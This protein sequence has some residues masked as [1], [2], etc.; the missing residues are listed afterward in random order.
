MALKVAKLDLWS[1][2][3]TD[4]PAGLASKLEG[5]AAAKVDLSFLFARRQPEKPGS[6][7]VFVGGIKGAKATKAA[8]AAGF[9]PAASVFG[10]RV[11]GPNRPGAAHAALAAVA[12]GGLNL[13][14]V[15]A[16][17]TGRRYV[18]CLAF[19]SADDA[20]RGQKLL[21]KVK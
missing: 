14:G 13:R 19:D 10:L 16:S 12:A 21:A 17:S 11:E 6:G 20:A 15:S 18:A 2:E 8:R 3:I 4:Q 7:L 1:A 5:L 9:A